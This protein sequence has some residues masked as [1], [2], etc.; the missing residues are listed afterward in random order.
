MYISIT[1]IKVKGFLGVIK[2]MRYTIPSFNTA[3]KTNGNLFCEAKKI[4]GYHHTLTVWENKNKMMDFFRSKHHTIAIKNFRS[5][6]K[7]SVYGYE[8]NTMPNWEEAIKKW[9]ENFREI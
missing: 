6:G 3:K 9:K 2:F 7:G 4:D 8:Q 5:I 1:G